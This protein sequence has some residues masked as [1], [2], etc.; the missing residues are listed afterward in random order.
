MPQKYLNMR[1]IVEVV[2][3]KGDNAEEVRNL[4][5]D[6]STVSCTVHPN[7]LTIKT[8]TCELYVDRSDY[9]TKNKNGKLDV[10]TQADFDAWFTP[11]DPPQIEEPVM[12]EEGR[13]DHIGLTMPATDWKSLF[14]Y[15]RKIRD[16]ATCWEPDDLGRMAALALTEQRLNMARLLDVI[17][18]NLTEEDELYRMTYYVR[19]RDEKTCSPIPN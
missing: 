19:P 16:P 15:L 10:I 1:A 8:Q 3:W 2:Q 12:V 18:R 13:P 14:D 11:Y 17:R 6:T 7:G 9:V 5:V 4:L